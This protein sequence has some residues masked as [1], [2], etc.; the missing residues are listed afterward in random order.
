[1]KTPT[2]QLYA[3]VRLV[4]C[5]ELSGM[6]GT[7]LGRSYTHPAMD[8]YIVLMDR[9]QFDGDGVEHAAVSITEHCMEPISDLAVRGVELYV[10]GLGDLPTRPAP[11]YEE[12]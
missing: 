7:V 9:N 12:A 4:R 2:Y 1:M 6:T 3:R 5:V 10:D 11:V 8:S